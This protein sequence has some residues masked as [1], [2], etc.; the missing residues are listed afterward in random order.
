MQRGRGV[1]DVQSASNL[2]HKALEEEVESLYAEILPVS[3]MSI[4][5]QHMEPALNTV[6]SRNGKDQHRTAAA[7]TY[8]TECLAHIID[9]TSRLQERV[10]STKIRQGTSLALKQIVDQELAATAAAEDSSSPCLR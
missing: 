10:A 3:Q 9:K 1:V 2:A 4:E 5:Q 7:V 6:T 8:I